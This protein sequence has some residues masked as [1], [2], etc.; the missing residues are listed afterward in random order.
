[1]MVLKKRKLYVPALSILGTVVILLIL[2]SVSTYRNLKWQRAQNLAFLEDKALTIINVLEAGVR[3][4]T[5]MRM[6]DEGLIRALMEEA[7]KEESIAYLYLCDRQGCVL[8]HSVGSI[9][10]QIS[11]W[12]PDVSETQPV[13]RRIRQSKNGGQ[14]FDIAK[15]FM[16]MPSIFK[17]APRLRQKIHL[18]HRN[19]IVLGMRMDNY[20]AARRS[21]LRHALIMGAIVVALGSGALF[22]LLVIQNVYALDRSLKKT[23]DLNRQ[24]ISAMAD[25]LI[26]LDPDGRIV[27][28]NPLARSLLHLGDGDIGGLALNHFLNLDLTGIGQTLSSGKAIINREISYQAPTGGTIPLSISATPIAGQGENKQGVVVLVRDLRKIKQ[29]E[30]EVRR[31]EN[32]ATIGRLA[33]GVAHEVRNPLSSIRGFAGY[34]AT[35]LKN[36]PKEKECAEIMVSEVDRINQVISEL[37]SLSRLRTPEMTPNSVAEVLAHVKALVEKDAAARRV[38]IHCNPAEGLNEIRFD[39]NQMIQVLLNLVINALNAVKDDEGIIELGSAPGDDGAEIRIWVKDN[40]MGIADAEKEK[41]FDPF[42]TRRQDGTGLGLAVV[43]NIIAGH[44]GSIQLCRPADNH[45]NGACFE[46]RLPQSI[47][48]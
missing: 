10:G 20:E 42:Y 40:G 25:G 43:N 37:L 28:A 22:F 44:G 36:R 47:Q 34:L 5:R 32:L 14:I 8:T 15:L 9:E 30:A 33:A 41:I 38:E 19:I 3:A 27:V 26:G 7:G 6:G 16:L 29:L 24:I 35:V 2:T 45:L 12:N 11:T 21:D 23:R 18:Q 4:G 39:R 48:E 46:I 13:A 17:T 31:S 1:M